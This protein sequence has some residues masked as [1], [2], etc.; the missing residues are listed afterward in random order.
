MSD[1]KQNIKQILKEELKVSLDKL[2]EDGI[3][4]GK[5]ALE[6]V[7]ME[8]SDCFARVAVRTDNKADD[9]YLMLRGMVEKE[10]DKIDGKEG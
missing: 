4:L 8:T 3:E 7:A 2:K 10:I 6:K 1:A 9:F 5:E